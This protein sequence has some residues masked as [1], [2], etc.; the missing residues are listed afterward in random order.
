M[1]NK[2]AG[3]VVSEVLML[4][5]VKK[6]YAFLIVE[7][8]DDWR[9]WKNRVHSLCEIV[10]ATGKTEGVIA[11]RRLNAR[12]FVGHVGVFDRDYKDAL[13]NSNWQANE[14]YWDA[15]SLETVLFCS[16]AFEA[17][18]VEYIDHLRLNALQTEVGKPMRDIVQW[19]AMTVGTVRYIHFLSGSTGDSSRLHPTNFLRAAPFKFDE[20]ALLA[21]GV[22]IGAAP[23]APQLRVRIAQYAQ[24]Q[25][26]LLMRGHDI[27]ALC[28][29][30][31][32]CCGG[33]CGHERVEQSFR[34][35]FEDAELAATTVYQELRQWETARTPRRIL[36]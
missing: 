10:D 12:G 2:T 23:S 26:R 20:A 8:R 24:I 33:A 25:A 21:V 13:T 5:S 6:D 11:V 7:G 27:S 30:M 16:G 3:E 4:H 1:Q 9:F 17:T 14:I 34:L 31:I 32:R 28:A 15:H 18:L 19:I 35:A 22:E 29:W 36:P